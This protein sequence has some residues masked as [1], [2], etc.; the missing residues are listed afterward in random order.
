MLWKRG[1]TQQLALYHLHRIKRL[2]VTQRKH[3]R[4]LMLL[5]CT[6][7]LLLLWKSGVMNSKKLQNE[8]KLNIN[9][10]QQQSQ[11]VALDAELIKRLEKSTDENMLK[12]L[13]DR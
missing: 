1:K 2:K 12:E 6:V 10:I 11:S 5:I 7:I 13:F 8:N 9:E 4:I 3:V